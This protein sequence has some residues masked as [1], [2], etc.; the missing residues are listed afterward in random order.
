[1]ILLNG[2]NFDHFTESV[3][4]RYF[5]FAFGEICGDSYLE[6]FLERLVEVESF[7]SRA[8]VFVWPSG[9]VEDG[10]WLLLEHR[11]A[12]LGSSLVDLLL[13]T[14]CASADF[15]KNFLRL[16]L[17]LCLLHFC[18]GIE[19]Q[20]L[21]WIEPVFRELLGFFDWVRNSFRYF[22]DFVSREALEYIWLAQKIADLLV[23]HAGMVQRLKVVRPIG[24]NTQIAGILCNLHDLR[25]PVLIPRSWFNTL[26]DRLFR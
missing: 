18:D 26:F 4:G 14:G 24:W 5:W 3:S 21:C 6:F 13:R 20:Q 8:L 17:L 11:L 25:S 12:K 22:A 19:Y 7:E 16:H 2:K 23:G 10:H 15:L 1:M 9:L